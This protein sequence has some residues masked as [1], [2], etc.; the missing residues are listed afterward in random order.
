MTD[1]LRCPNR[2]TRAAM[3]GGDCDF[4]DSRRWVCP[5]CG[6][7]FSEQD[8]HA[9]VGGTPVPITAPAAAGGVDAGL[10]ADL[11]RLPKQRVFDDS[12]WASAMFRASVALAT[13]HRELARERAY[14]AK[15]T[16]AMVKFVPAFGWLHEAIEK[17]GT[18]AEQAES[19]AAALR[20]HIAGLEA[21]LTA[22]DTNESRMMNDAAALREQVV[23][24]QEAGRLLYA[25][26]DKLREQVAALTADAQRYR[27]LRSEQGSRVRICTFEHGS[28]V[29]ITGAEADAAID[30]ARQ[31]QR[32]DAE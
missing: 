26:T 3:H 30:V 13:A 2:C 11:R 14:H 24:Q 29:V 7:A 27:R 5:S 28:A 22:R 8:G 21:V 20:R 4:D 6:T 10:I 12:E 18:R 19:D 31:P 17:L 16:V 32:P 25:A 15:C 9:C 1:D 23:A